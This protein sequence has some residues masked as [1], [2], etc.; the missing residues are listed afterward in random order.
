MDNQ[1]STFQKYFS[2]A[3]IIKDRDANVRITDD[4]LLYASDVVM[5]VTGKNCNHSNAVL[6][7]LDS[8]S[9]CNKKFVIRNTGGA[10]NSKTKLLS[11]QDAIDLIMVLP[12]RL[13]KDIRSKFADIIRRYLAGDR[14]LIVALEANAV[15][16]SPVARL[17]R[18]SAKE[19]IGVGK[20]RD[21]DAGHLRENMME[22]ESQSQVVV[23]NMRETTEL[24]KEQ[25]G[26]REREAA[27][28]SKERAEVE[29]HRTHEINYE[30]EL[31]KIAKEKASLALPAQPAAPMA[32]VPEQPLDYLPQNH[33]TVKRVFENNRGQFAGIK[34]TQIN[35]MLKSA[36]VRAKD[37]Y[38][39]QYGATP[40][41]VKESGFN[42]FYY[43]PGAHDL[44]LESLRGA[45]GELM[46]GRGFRPIT[47]F[48]QL[49]LP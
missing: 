6:R 27:L 18:D 7:E 26:I 24:M 28:R 30:R 38:Q 8:S 42:V 3:D 48:V 17:A 9:F 45:Y 10:G 2:F 14:S 16:D 29:E 15:S 44:V 4:D 23:V 13:A 49:N 25:F 5:V 41:Q 12:G 33:V 39:T 22:L 40:K 32:P 31:L 20:K 21:R 19:T 11:F 34:K 46:V 47:A 37:S 35:S 1:V 36:G 43:P